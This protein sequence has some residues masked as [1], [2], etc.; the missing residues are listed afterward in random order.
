M[1]RVNL[2]TIENTPRITDL[3]D[4][5]NPTTADALKSKEKRSDMFEV[6]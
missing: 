6:A 3:L 2:A 1:R 4:I 5:A